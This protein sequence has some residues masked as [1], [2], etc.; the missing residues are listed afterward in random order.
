MSNKKWLVHQEKWKKIEHKEQAAKKYWK[1][2]KSAQLS[3]IDMRKP[4]S[5]FTSF[6]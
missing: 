6:A 5:L 3:E 1:K 4:L 2:N